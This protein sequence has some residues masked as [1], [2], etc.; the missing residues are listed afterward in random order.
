MATSVRRAY[1]PQLDD[2]VVLTIP[3]RLDL[4]NA[5]QKRWLRTGLALAAVAGVLMLL[6]RIHREPE[7]H[8]LVE[9]RQAIAADLAGT[10]DGRLSENLR[11]YRRAPGPVRLAHA[12]LPLQLDERLGRP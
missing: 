11:L 9:D 6:S 4:R 2:R 5:R 1:V 10:Y 12:A 3:S 7:E 8:T